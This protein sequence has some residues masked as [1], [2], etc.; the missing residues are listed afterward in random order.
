VASGFTRSEPEPSEDPEDHSNYCEID[1]TMALDADDSPILPLE[2]L[3]GDAVLR[4]VNWKTQSGGL[5]LSY[6]AAT[7]LES[8]WAEKLESLEK[9]EV[10]R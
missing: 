8:L 7:Q 5:E 10:K 6:E 9:A 4:D 3:K 1:F 2:T